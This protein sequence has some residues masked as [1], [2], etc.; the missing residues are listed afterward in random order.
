MSW[1]SFIG[2]VFLS[3]LLLMS[4]SGSSQERTIGIKTNALYWGAMT[5][6]LGVEMALGRKWSINIDGMYA[7]WNFKNNKKYLGWAIQP[8]LRLW[9][10][11]VFTRHYVGLHYH[12]ARYNIGQEMYRRDGHLMGGGITYGYIW[13]INDKWNIDF[14]VGVGYA[15]IEYDKFMQECNLLVTERSRNYWG[16]TKAGITFV[17]K[18]HY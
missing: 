12:Y 2:I 3:C 4:L 6:N 17:Y 18:I 10:C 13:V 15:R 14:N 8:E 7:P 16:P 11:Q 1:K 5:P 9:C